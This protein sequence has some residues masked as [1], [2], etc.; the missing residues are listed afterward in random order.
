MDLKDIIAMLTIDV[1]AEGSIGT[2]F[3][4]TLL[5]GIFMGGGIL[6]IIELLVNM[7]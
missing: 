7:I 1:T 5:I 6:P 3:A 4:I 2:V